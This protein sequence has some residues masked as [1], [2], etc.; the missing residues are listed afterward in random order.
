[1]S[2]KTDVVIA[3]SGPAGLMAAYMAAM[4]IFWVIRKPANVLKSLLRP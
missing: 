2:R 4:W 3:G 1:M